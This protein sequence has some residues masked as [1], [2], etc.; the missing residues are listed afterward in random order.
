MANNTRPY[1]AVIGDR[2][3]RLNAPSVWVAAIRGALKF[4][5]RQGNDFFYGKAVLKVYRH[6]SLETPIY[7]GNVEK[8]RTAL[9]RQRYTLT[10]P[11]V[12]NPNPS[13]TGQELP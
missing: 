9:T 12:P 13:S 5:P 11:W 3:H 4:P 6:D 7:E 2:M 10:G 1:V 8:W